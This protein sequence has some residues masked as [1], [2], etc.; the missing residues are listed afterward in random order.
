MTV[1]VRQRSACTSSPVTTHKL[2]VMVVS[3]GRMASRLR[4]RETKRESKVNGGAYPYFWWKLQSSEWK[5]STIPLSGNYL[6][7]LNDQFYIVIQQNCRAGAGTLENLALKC[8]QS[9]PK[10][11]FWVFLVQLGSENSP[12]RPQKSKLGQKS[13]T[14]PQPDMYNG[15][16]MSNSFFWKN[17]NR[18]VISHCVREARLLRP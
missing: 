15:V 2:L 5:D 10:C 12:W 11:H 8:A 6:R 4:C 7:H 17:P 13:I 14:T 3:S 16:E 1:C 9:R 18:G